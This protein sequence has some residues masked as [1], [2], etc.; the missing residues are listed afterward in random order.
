[1]PPKSNIWQVFEK[2][3][4]SSKCRLCLA[5]IKTSGNTT[6]LRTHLKRRHADFSL[7]KES[8]V[9]IILNNL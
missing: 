2:N 4:N 5:E 8:K 9:T 6:N 7:E 1:M 3:K